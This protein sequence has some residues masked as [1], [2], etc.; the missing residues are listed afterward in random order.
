MKLTE[1]L[2][3]LMSEEN[4]NKVELSKSSGIP[5]MTIVNFYEKGTDNVKLSTL[6]KLSS[7]FRVSLDYLVDD[8]CGGTNFSV[9]EDPQLYKLSNKI[10]IVGVIQAGEPILAEQ[11]IIGY[12]ELPSEFVGKGEEYFGLRV[13][14]NSMNLSRISDGDI[15]IVR[16]QNYVEN[17]EIAVILIDGK[18]V[19][20][21]KYYQTDTII[22]LI[23]NSSDP[24]HSPIIYDSGK[25]PLA[26]L[27]KVVK[28]I[29]YF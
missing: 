8:N 10:P 27:G 11:N 18:N 9:K 17:G 3:F 29:I 20:V 4:I 28:A 7:Y 2:D 14:G 5:Y 1:K 13:I 19:S 15:V 22:T 24:A 23:P 21:K 6:K 12:V 25:I 26:I 16:M